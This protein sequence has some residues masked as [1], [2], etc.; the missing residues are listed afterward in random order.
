MSQNQNNYFTS[1]IRRF[2]S[3]DFIMALKPEQI[4]RSAKER[5]FREMVLGQIDYT[6]FG[7]YFL[8]SLFLSNLIIAADNELTN[9][10]VVSQALELFDLTYPGRVEV[11]RN[12]ARYQ[13]LC[14]MYNVLLDRL[15]TVQLTGNVGALTDIQYVLN[16]IK[17][18]I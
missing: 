7:K 11:I 1:Q 17:P 10:T 13:N 3:D 18:F 5:L 4:Q 15:N 9:N 2:Q 6:E 12:R 16:G 8:F 14:I